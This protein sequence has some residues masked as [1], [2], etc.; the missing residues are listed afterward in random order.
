MSKLTLFATLVLFG[1]PGCG[2]QSEAS[3]PPATPGSDVEV[4]SD[5]PAASEPAAS[6]PSSTEAE[7]S[8]S[9]KSESGKSESGKSGANQQANA[10][11]KGCTGLKKETCEITLGCAWSTKKVCVEQ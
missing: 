8:E 1:L 10:P 7:P 9:G 5:E 6:E 2:G 11:K 3:K 4:K